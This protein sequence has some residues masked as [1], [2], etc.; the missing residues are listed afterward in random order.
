MMAVTVTSD[1]GS[2]E[3]K[4]TTKPSRKDNR[5]KS[6]FRVGGGGWVA[7]EL[8]LII[9]WMKEK[10]NKNESEKKR[11]KC[12]LIHF[13]LGDGNQKQWLGFLLITSTE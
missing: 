12:Q 8:R 4:I 5:M 3:C 6:T 2:G 7:H 1:D 9:E 10:A 13:M 11:R